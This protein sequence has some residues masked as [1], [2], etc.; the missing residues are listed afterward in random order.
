MTGYNNSDAPEESAASCLR[1]AGVAVGY[2]DAPIVRDV[3]LDVP[4]GALTV[5]V[6]PNGSGKSTLMKAMA[7]VLPV[8]SGEIR[9]DGRPIGAMPTR[10]VAKRL[11]LLPQGPIAPEGLRVR[12]LVAQGRYPHQ[13]LLRQWSR[14]DAEAV[15]AAMQA[16][17][18][19]GFADRPVSELS[20]GQRQRCWIAMVLA[21]ETDILLLD[22]P[23]T[24]L[25]LKV[26][27]DLMRLLRRIAKED[28]RT[29]VVVLHEL[30]VAAAFADHLIMMQDGRILAEGHVERVFTAANLREVFG[31][32]ANVLRDPASGRPVCVP[33][34]TPDADVMSRIAAQ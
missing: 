21:Q 17:D 6:G 15:E 30:N 2:G 29:L 3:S 31:L 12:E 8:R 33:V 26:Q 32:E 24:F 9:L 23:T 22:E 11:A 20:G 7:R 34:V 27:V 10:E 14:R 16:A 25:D 5:L 19:I 13:S 18:V 28:G 1:V 4:D